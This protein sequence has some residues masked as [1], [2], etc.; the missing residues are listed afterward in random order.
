MAIAVVMCACDNKKNNNVVVNTD[1]WETISN[2]DSKDV[3]VRFL[4]GF[5]N[6][7][8]DVS[9]SK[10]NNSK[11]TGTS[12][13]VT[14]NAKVFLCVNDN[15][16]WFSFKGKYD[17][18]DPDTIKDKAI[19]SFELSTSEN[20]DDTTRLASVFLYKNELYV[21][22]GTN[23]VKFS[24][25]NTD[26]TPYY[27]FTIEELS[28]EKLSQ[29]ASM[30]VTNLTLN[31]T[32]SGKK[33]VNDGKDEYNYT[34]D[35]DL[36]STLSNLS[37]NLGTFLSDNTKVDQTKEFIANIFGVTVEQLDNNELPQGSLELTFITSGNRMSALN[38][39]INLDLNE[40]DSKL[41][42][43][44]DLKVEADIKSLTITNDY[45]NGVKIDFVN[46]TSERAS[47]KLYDSAIY[48]L[49][50]PLETN[51]SN[52]YDMKVT[53]RIFQNDSTNNFVFLEYC[54]KKT[55]KV[56]NA[57]YFYKNVAYV[58]ITKDG[59]SN[60]ECV[61]KFNADLS[62]LATKMVT[63]D[64]AEKSEFNIYNAVAYVIH[65]LSLTTE[66]VLFAVKSDFYSAIWY[67]FDDTL[68]YLNSLDPDN[69]IY[70]MADTKYL[71]DF[72]TE[73]QVVYDI[74]YN[75]EFLSVIEVGDA[76]ITAVTDML[77]A[78]DTVPEQ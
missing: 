49:V 76:K 64:F 33:R 13:A 11:T 55:D 30:F 47:Y 46:D 4:S 10:I 45:A 6:V 18:S 51:G 39:K 5:I 67:N 48:S 37:K 58:Y 31:N 62:V 50:F 69:D 28:S 57:V 35:I 21:A 54:D 65:N 16:L 15:N 43:G 75:T 24:V 56:R 12:T 41:F 32:I 77:E 7:A 27:P 73:N 14:G 22:I 72:V 68:A 20:A 59:E 60:A 9:S 2:I 1:G 8:S 29:M 25:A 19:A 34:L 52:D 23:K 36:D 26:W 74:K 70:T 40:T 53:T 3:Y 78:L 44:D 42:D 63:N 17:C 66:E 38:S 61:Y 71:I